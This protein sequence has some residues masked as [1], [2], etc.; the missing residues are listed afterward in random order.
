M[1]ST[2]WPCP[3]AG[4]FTKPEIESPR[5]VDRAI[6]I[7]ANT[8][9]AAVASKARR[10]RATGRVAGPVAGRCLEPAGGKELTCSTRP[11]S[12]ARGTARRGFFPLLTRLFYPSIGKTANL[13]SVPGR[14]YI[15]PVTAGNSNEDTS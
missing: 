2:T 13:D 7:S 4:P 9:I 8:R 10:G 1:P 12:F 3:P 14:P 6:P 5:L 11:F 15:Y